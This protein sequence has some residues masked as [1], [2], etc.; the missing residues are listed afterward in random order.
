MY[1]F[2]YGMINR[3]GATGSLHFSMAMYMYICLDLL[4]FTEA[5][6]YKISKAYRS[7]NYKEVIIIEN[8]EVNSLHFTEAQA[9]THITISHV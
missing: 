4:K 8:T 2:V 1:C 5:G 7:H 9:Y 6:I 3:A